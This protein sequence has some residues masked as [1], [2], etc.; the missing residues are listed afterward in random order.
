MSSNKTAFI[1]FFSKYTFNY[2]S[3][4]KLYLGIYQ[5]ELKRWFLLFQIKD[6]LFLL[7]VIGNKI[8]INFL[9]GMFDLRNVSQSVDGGLSFVYIFKRQ[10][11]RRK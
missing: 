8:I 1:E 2:L 11:I 4:H 3:M 10:G 7:N 5:K 6:F 9:L